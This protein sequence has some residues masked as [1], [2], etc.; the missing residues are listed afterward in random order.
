MICVYSLFFF[1]FIILHALK[2][3]HSREIKTKTKTDKRGK[4]SQTTKK[5]FIR[6][7]AQ[8]GKHMIQR[9]KKRRKN[10]PVCINV[11]LFHKQQVSNGLYNSSSFLKIYI[12]TNKVESSTS[13][14][15]EIEI[16]SRTHT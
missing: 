16:N 5:G 9:A 8:H 4:I 6:K 14:K 15:I 13:R 3:L 7:Y 10:S 2:T 12:Y 1:R 11:V